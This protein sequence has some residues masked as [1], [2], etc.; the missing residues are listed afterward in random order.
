MHAA[1]FSA[2][3]L[4]VLGLVAHLATARAGRAVACLVALLLADVAY[5]AG[6]IQRLV[7]DLIAQ[8][9]A[10]VWALCIHMPVQPALTALVV[11]AHGVARPALVVQPTA[12]YTAL[13]ALPCAVSKQPAITALGCGAMLAVMAT[14]SAA[15]THLRACH[16][17]T[18]CSRYSC[19]RSGSCCSSACSCRN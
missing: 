15:P 4:A 12:S 16:R 5:N 13:A 7:P 17:P 19:R 8:V 9:A 11:Y 14:L 6:A 2:S 1:N 10:D 3:A 18:V